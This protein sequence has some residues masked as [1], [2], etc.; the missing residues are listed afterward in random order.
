MTNNANVSLTSCARS[1]GPDSTSIPG[2][3]AG[4]WATCSSVSAWAMKAALARLIPRCAVCLR[5]W[6]C[7]AQ[8]RP[9][10]LG[11]LNVGMLGKP[12]LMKAPEG[13]RPGPTA[14]HDVLEGLLDLEMTFIT[15]SAKTVYRRT[16]TG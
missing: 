6:Y 8:W 4:V 1:T 2:P 3:G 12:Q 13:L 11:N 7:G 10:S 15:T 14:R 16:F 9:T 5:T